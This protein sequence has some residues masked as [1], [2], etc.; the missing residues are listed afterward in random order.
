[1]PGTDLEFEWDS[2][3]AAINLRIHRVSF[4]EASTVFRD[5]FSFIYDD[6]VHSQDE[7][8]YVTLGMFDRGRILVVAHAMRDERIRVISARKATRF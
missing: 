8:R 5:V 3:K 6:P 1:M 2:R 4:R 7:L